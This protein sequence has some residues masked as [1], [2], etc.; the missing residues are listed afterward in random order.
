MAG[1]VHDALPALSKSL[2]T[3]GL[4]AAGEMWAPEIGRKHG[5]KSR[6]V[7]KEFGSIQRQGAKAGIEGLLGNIVAD[8]IPEGIAGNIDIGAMLP[9]LLG[10]GKGGNGA[11]M[12]GQQ[13]QQQGEQ[14]PR[15]G[16]VV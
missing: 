8:Y 13:E 10:A 12:L 7:S 6:Y 9:A 15:L 4:H 14:P 11:P 1:V 16:R 2:V 3:E 5:S